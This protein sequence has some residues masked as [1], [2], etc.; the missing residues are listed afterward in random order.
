M[1]S[2]YSP[3]RRANNSRFRYS[4]DENYLESCWVLHLKTTSGDERLRG[5]G[6]AG[7]EFPIS[8]LTCI[9]ALTTLAVYVSFP[10][11]SNIMVLPKLSW[12][13]SVSGQR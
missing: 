11:V 6:V 13:K 1:R 8:P 3:D 5:L 4:P 12:F 7:V 2:C 10:A 9:V